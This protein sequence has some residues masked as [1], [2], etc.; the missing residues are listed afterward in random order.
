[1]NMRTARDNSMP[2]FKST[3][4][5]AMSSVLAK[6][7]SVL[8]WAFTFTTEIQFFVI[9]IV[10]VSYRLKQQIKPV[11][12]FIQSFFLNTFFLPTLIQIVILIFYYKKIFF[13]TTF[14]LLCHACKVSVKVSFYPTWNFRTTR[15]P[16]E[17]HATLCQKVSSQISFRCVAYSGSGK[18]LFQF[19]NNVSSWV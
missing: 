13:I 11:C 8:R 15:F 2:K 16:L 17:K 10:R 18:Q 14:Y 7:P 4:C 5:C 3:W 19:N 9:S 12:N 1:M 6:R